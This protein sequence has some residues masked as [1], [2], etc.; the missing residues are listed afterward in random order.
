MPNLK[1]LTKDTA[2]Y[3]LSSIV[4]RFLNYLLVPIY[5]HAIASA[6]GG[7]GIVTNIYANTAFFLVLLTF[8]METT[9]LRFANKEGED[10]DTV[11][12]NAFMFVSTLALAFFGLVTLGIEPLARLM[13]YP[14]HHN[15]LLLM[16]AVVALDAIQAIPFVLLRYQKRAIK[17]VSLKLLFILLNTG[18]NLLY[19]V[20]LG[21]SDVIYV[22]ALNLVC[23]GLITFFFIPEVMRIRWKLDTALLGRMLAYAWPMLLLGIAGILNQTFDKMIYPI[24]APDPIEGKVQLGIYGACIKIAMIMAMITQAFR[25]AYEPI[26]FAT[27]NEAGSEGDKKRYYAIAMK[28]FLIFTLLAFLA[29]VGYMDLLK[30]LIDVDYRVGLH[31]VPIVMAAEIMMG[32]YFNLSFWY[33]LIDRPIWGAWFSLVGCAVLMAINI[34]GIPRFGYM[35]CAWGGFAGYATCMVLSYCVGQRYNPFPYDLR[36]MGFYTV[37][38]LALYAVMSWLPIES[39]ILRMGVNTLLLAVYLGVVIRRDLPLT[40]LIKRLRKK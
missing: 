31:V 15:Y 40:P 19:F 25:Y 13:H 33:K 34:W 21:K 14:D 18:L 10:P 3:G 4:G 2:I 22:F 20:V 32:I 16:A 8:G 36:S 7:Y 11:F 39:A 9:Y 17:F 35:A 1:A 29:V 12:S 5:T 28:Y 6:G 23:T 24:V 30:H 27:N 26:V 38:A 37:L